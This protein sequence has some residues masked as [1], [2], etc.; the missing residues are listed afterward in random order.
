M[1]ANHMHH[2]AIIKTNIKNMQ[3]S[4]HLEDSFAVSLFVDWSSLTN[5]EEKL[6]SN[7]M[8]ICA[9]LSNDTCNTPTIP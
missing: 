7:M 4:Y 1:G 6:N 9:G 3:H 5:T 8:M 2:L